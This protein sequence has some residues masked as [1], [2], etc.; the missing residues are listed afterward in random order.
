MKELIIILILLNF[1]VRSC[2]IAGTDSG[3]TL[4]KM[5]SNQYIINLNMVIYIIN[6][7]FNYDY[8]KGVCVNEPSYDAQWRAT[9]M[10]FCGQYVQ[11]ATC[12]PKQQVI[13]YTINYLIYY[14]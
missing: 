2:Y 4:I 3:L 1:V 9:N 11:Y 13:F 14:N 12:V 7:N 8:I 6:C 10:P 5:L